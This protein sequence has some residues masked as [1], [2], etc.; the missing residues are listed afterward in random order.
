MTI[1][2]HIKRIV[3]LTALAFTTMG[4]YAQ[5]MT[6]QQT[7]DYINNNIDSKHKIRLDSNGKLSIINHENSNDFENYTITSFYLL[8]VK[9]ST[10]DGSPSTSY[11]IN[12]E[13]Q[14]YPDNCIQAD[15]YGGEPRTYIDKSTTLFVEGVK[16]QRIF[17][18][19][20]HLKDLVGTEE[21]FQHPYDPD[22]FSN[23]N[24]KKPNVVNKTNQH[25]SKSPIDA[26]PMIRSQ[27]GLYEIPVTINGVLKIDFILDSGASDVSISSDVAL[28]L[29]KTGTVKESDFI[30]SEIYTFAD[31]SKATSR[32]FIIRKLT[33][34]NHVIYNVRASITESIDAP[35]LLGQSVLSR[36]GKMVVDNDSHTLKFEK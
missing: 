28:T 5:D 35:M 10:N 33:I 27:N 34:G 21:R 22:P 17:N 15:Y 7:V 18:A 29:I 13:C 31:G 12:F 23:V 8:K 6:I 30:G 26:I 3:L 24:Y 19:F 2:T 20:D 4:A 9:I 36:F 11:S 32:V 25:D 16:Q 1:K 14:E